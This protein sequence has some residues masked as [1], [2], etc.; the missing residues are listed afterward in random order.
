MLDQLDE[1]MEK[2]A[3]L[4]NLKYSG[5]DA[6]EYQDYLNYYN[7][8]SELSQAM[9]E[10]GARMT[11]KAL[12]RGLRQT[13]ANDIVPMEQ[14]YLRR[15]EEQKVLKE[16]QMKD[17]DLLVG[18]NPSMTGLKSYLDPNFT[19]L[20]QTLSGRDLTNEVSAMT[21][22]IA[23]DL[24]SV[25][26]LGA[27]EGTH[28]T[29]IKIL[30]QKGY[31]TSDI[32]K[33]VNGD[34]TSKSAQIL[35][36]IANHVL[37]SKGITSWDAWND[38]K[39]RDRAWSYATKGWYSGIGESDI[40]I[41]QD[42]FAV[43]ALKKKGSG[44]KKK[45]KP[46][47]MNDITVEYENSMLKD[48]GVKNFESARNVVGLGHK[49]GTF[50]TNMW[51]KNG[52]MLS[53]EEWAKA[54]G[55][56]DMAKGT[57]GQWAASV[58][59]ATST[60]LPITGTG[61]P[62]ARYNQMAKFLSDINAPK[63]DFDEWSKYMQGE[64]KKSEGDKFKPWTQQEL[65]GM[66]NSA[67]S[68]MYG[69]YRVQDVDPY[70]RELDAEGE[71]S[72]KKNSKMFEIQVG[73]AERELLENKLGSILRSS[74]GK[75]IN[76]TKVSRVKHGG[77]FEKGMDDVVKY[78]DYYDDKGKLKGNVSILFSDKV[79]N[80]DVYLNIDGETLRLGKN[81][82]GET[83]R[84]KVEEA[85]YMYN[86]YGGVITDAEKAFNGDKKALER[87]REF[88]KQVDERRGVSQLS[89][90]D[91]RT[92]LGYVW[93]IARDSAQVQ[94]ETMYDTYTEAVFGKSAGRS[95]TVGS[96][97]TVNNEEDEED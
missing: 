36:E 38:E 73:P 50:A 87:C 19:A 92:L 48:Y 91:D 75:N 5:I 31:R 68:Y 64:K 21:K 67:D 80:E 74:N 37:E 23:N 78:G 82:L 24:V 62:M 29:L 76:A 13:Y 12:M 71:F 93:Q 46:T 86:Y 90:L 7:Q 45:Q 22:Q 88:A 54:N 35:N 52:V 25:S 11:D 65:W 56:K 59:G 44:T 61:D 14:A 51:N 85:T 97:E 79:G 10:R 17:S 89:L 81:A 40:S 18:N 94:Y 53:P 39:F 15:A 30:K 96:T 3:V 28:G 34:T 20:N 41:Q 6:A 69:V 77:V 83:A 33:A 95:Y 60:M 2:G 84:A 1:Q 66:Y 32:Q 55:V 4:N 57:P 70:L 16:A 72:A 58:T 8:L 9:N 42:P 49:P 63:W 47:P 27:L 26:N 43:A